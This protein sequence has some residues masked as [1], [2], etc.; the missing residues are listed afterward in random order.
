MSAVIADVVPASANRYS[1]CAGAG[2]DPPASAVTSGGSTQASAV[3][4]TESAI[5]TTVSFC[6]P[7]VTVEPVKTPAPRAITICALPAGQLPSSSVRSSTG[8]PGE[9]RPTI[10]SESADVPGVP[11]TAT[12][13][14][15][16][17]LEYGPAA[18]VTPASR[19]VAAISDDGATEGSTTVVTSAPLC[20]ANARSNGPCA[21]ASKPRATTEVAVDASTTTAMITACSLRPLIPLRAAGKTALTAGPRCRRQCA[22]RRSR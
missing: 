8:P 12:C 10:R 7:T 9:E 21:L 16:V 14:V 5:P 3:P 6:D 20:R 13:A 17:T 18:A 22:R 15:T 19:V 4:V 11:G 1:I 2:F